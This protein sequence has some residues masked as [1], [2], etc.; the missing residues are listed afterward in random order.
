MRRRYWIEPQRAPGSTPALRPRPRMVDTAHAYDEF[1]RM[2][3][4]DIEASEFD[5]R[6][7]VLDSQLCSQ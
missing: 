4:A 6:N 5:A 7:G 3:V 1:H 2:P